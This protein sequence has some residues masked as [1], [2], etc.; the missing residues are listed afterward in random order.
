MPRPRLP[1]VE[2]K[3]K[4]DV[5]LVPKTTVDEEKS[6]PNAKSGDVVALVVVP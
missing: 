2:L 4:F 6:P 5:P 1:V 3:R